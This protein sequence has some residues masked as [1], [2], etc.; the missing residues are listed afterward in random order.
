MPAAESG[1]FTLVSRAG[2]QVGQF[3]ALGRLPGLVHAVTTRRGLDV[4]LAK[5]DPAAAAMQVAEDLGLDAVAFCNQAHGA[6]VI[7]VASGGPVGDGD[8][9]VTAQAGV[10]VMGF[11]ADCPLVLAA[12]ASGPAVGV[13]HASWRGT[14]RGVARR[15]IEQ[16]NAAFGTDPSDVVACIAPSAGPCCYEIGPDVLD[17]AVRHLGLAAEHF[18]RERRPGTFVFDLWAANRDQ[19]IRA[20]VR[21]GN[22]HVAG[23]CTICRNDLFP[24]YRAEGPA[25][26]RFVAAIGIEGER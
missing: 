13:A 18:F 15:M 25:A 9:L 6:E 12:D 16:L 10:G 8:A 26:G 19:L 24:S 23:L 5:S 4:G 22:V 17:A 11:A 1:G 2:G 3:D 21:P 20:G 14:V 7:R